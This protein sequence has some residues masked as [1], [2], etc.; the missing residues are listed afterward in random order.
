MPRTTPEIKVAAVRRH[1]AEVELVGDHYADAQRHAE[2][3]SSESGLVFIHP[4]D[5]PLV[6]AGQGTVAVE[7]LRQCREVAAV[8]VPVGGGGLVAGMGAYIKAL[9]PEIRVVGV[10]PIDADALARS[11]EAGTRV[12]LEGVGLFADGVAVEQVGAYTFPIA[13]ATV[14]RCTGGSPTGASSHAAS[15]AA[16]STRERSNIAA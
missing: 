10:E 9:V 11:L 8:F 3:T 14:P 5:D 12:K 7:L 4:F 16:G 13:Q 2:R 15:S 6:I 1:G